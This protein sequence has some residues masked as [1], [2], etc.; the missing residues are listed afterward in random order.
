ME[1]KKPKIISQEEYDKQQQEA[2]QVQIRMDN[3]AIQASINQALDGWTKGQDQQQQA[4][5]LNMQA[6]IDAALNRW[7]AQ[8]NQEIASQFESQRYQLAAMQPS[9][10]MPA[11]NVEAL[12]EEVFASLSRH[13]E[14]KIE[15]VKQ[16]SE[17]VARRQ[18]EALTRFVQVTEAKLADQI[19]APRRSSE[20]PTTSRGE[21]P[22]RSTEA[23]TEPHLAAAPKP[24][25]PSLLR[26]PANNDRTAQKAEVF[27]LIDEAHLS[28]Y[29]VAE[30]T[31]VPAGAIQ[32]WL[33]ERAQARK[34]ALSQETGQ[35]TG[36]AK[37]A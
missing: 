18:N 23:S 8:Q 15:A 13:F 33:S 29:K 7:T 6:L 25:G 3:A 9:N 35:A 1:T 32:R 37:E 28:T 17:A 2:E 34:A 22:R 16:Q 26:L 10:Q 31:N 4:E 21:A 30:M 27:R 24:S 5:R 12:T 19:E 36:E 11:L 20:A 14:S